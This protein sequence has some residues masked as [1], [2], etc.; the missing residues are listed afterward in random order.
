MSRLND[1]GEPYYSW[2]NSE[3]G[4]S[5]NTPEKPRMLMSFLSLS[6]MAKRAIT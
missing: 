1:Q 6:D 2:G 5:T 4:A 3:D